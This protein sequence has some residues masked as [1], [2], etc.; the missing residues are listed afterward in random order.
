MSTF[1]LK[2]LQGTL[3]GEIAQMDR[4]NIKTTLSMAGMLALL[5]HTFKTTMINMLGCS[6]GKSRET[7]KTDG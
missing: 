2:K 5:D 6:N 3:Q 4:V 1:Q 7:V